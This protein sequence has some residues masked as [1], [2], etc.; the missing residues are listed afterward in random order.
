MRFGILVSM[1]FL[2]HLFQ[3]H[4]V[5]FA[6]GRYR[7]PFASY[8]LVGLHFPCL[9]DRVSHVIIIG[10]FPCT[11]NKQKIVISIWIYFTDSDFILKAKPLT[12][13]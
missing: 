13:K 12:S 11:L 3:S 6:R 1:E 8:E 9:E 7:A 5:R 4:D 10:L 2:R